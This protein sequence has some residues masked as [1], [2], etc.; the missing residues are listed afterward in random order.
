MRN[1][2]YILLLLMIIPVNTFAI[3]F[4]CDRS[5]KSGGTFNCII[6]NSSNSLY[7]FVANLDYPSEFIVKNE[8]Y[9]KGYT[10][11]GSTKNINISGPGFNA[12]TTIAMFTFLAPTVSSTQNYVFSL[13]NMKYKYLETENNFRDN[14]SDLIVNISVNAS[15]TTST[16]TTT[17]TPTTTTKATTTSKVT[18]TKNVQENKN[19]ELKLNYG[20]DDKVEV[21]SCESVDGKCIIDLSSANIPVK[22]GYEFVGWNQNNS[23]DN[24]KNYDLYNLSANAELFACFKIKTDEN[25]VN[26]LESL[27]IKNLNIQFNKYIFGYVINLEGSTSEL[28]IEAVPLNKDAKVEI[29]ENAK[30]LIDGINKVE[31]RVIYNDVTTIYT[32]TVYKNYK[33]EAKLNNININGYDL[34]FNKDIYNYNLVVKYGIKNLDVTVDCDELYNYAISGN[35]LITDGSKIL[36]VVKGDN[37]ETSTYTI[38]IKYES[39]IKSYLP[40]IYSVCFGLFCIIVY[41]VVRYLRNGKF[42]DKEQNKKVQ[43]VNIDTKKKG[44]IKKEKKPKKEKKT[45]K[46]IIEKL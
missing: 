21:L 23:C 4:Y 19:L 7:N 36:V 46:E 6:S 3:E 13:K 22:D 11:N 14:Q 20:I 9:S 31:V 38:N 10:N 12:P 30:N 37:S 5:V 34:N 27:L 33:E 32:I 24:P 15:T 16:T 17:K 41:F 25:V 45:N 29:S 18:T 35:T 2:K 43:G 40:Y 26:Y 39:F 42:K 1:L 44:K 28:D 8:I